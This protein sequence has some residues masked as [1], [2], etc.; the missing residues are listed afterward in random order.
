[1]KT[2]IVPPQNSTI[3]LPGVTTPQGVQKA[4][5]IVIQETATTPEVVQVAN[6]I[7]RSCPVENWPVAVACFAYDVAFFE[8]DAQNQIIRTPRRTMEDARANCVDY[9][10]LIGAICRAMG[11]PVT[12]RIVQ[13]DGAKNYGHVFPVVNGVPLDVVPG[14]NQTG[15][16]YRTRKNERPYMLGIEVPYLR[17]IDLVV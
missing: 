11:Q 9:T 6:A 17:C 15:A 13:F 16:E 4:M 5:K 1:M 10:V 8:P 3:K 2:P 14:Q 12:I 7:M